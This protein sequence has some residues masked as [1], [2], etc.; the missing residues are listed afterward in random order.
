M[1]VKNGVKARDS[2][3]NVLDRPL[4]KEFAWAYDL[5]VS[6]LA[7]VRC[8]FLERMFSQRGVQP[9]SKI[10]DAGCGTGNYSIE[11]ARRGY[12]VT[13]I[14]ISSELIFLAEKKKKLSSL[15][16]AFREG[17]ILELPSFSRFDG[18]LCRGVLN[19][20]ID[21]TSRR[22]V[23]LSFASSLRKSGTLILDVREW[24]STAARKR[25]EP[26]FEKSINTKEGKIT[27]QSITRLDKETRQMLIKE[28]FRIERDGSAETSEYDFIMK[29]WTKSEL[30]DYLIN[31]GFGSIDYFGEYD[32]EKPLGTTERIVA[33]ASLKGGTY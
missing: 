3:E 28:R 11:L 24:E 29:C 33:A 19:D 1:T 21:D 15:S 20:V 18:I 31:A 32:F 6:D 8:N 4:Y 12:D 26:L 27:F 17:N 14:D 30:D 5:I 9:G 22:E 25:K 10:L 13:G 2:K 23:F 7:L 16:L